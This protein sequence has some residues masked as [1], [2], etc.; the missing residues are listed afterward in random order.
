MKHAFIDN[1]CSLW[2]VGITTI[3]I[4]Q[5]KFELLSAPKRGGS[6]FVYEALKKESIGTKEYEHR[7]ILKEFYPILD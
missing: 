6:C 4:R 3:Y 1:R 5:T 7:V 2:D